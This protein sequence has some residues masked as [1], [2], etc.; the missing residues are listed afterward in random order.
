[1][2]R[3]TLQQLCHFVYRRDSCCY[4]TRFGRF[5]SMSNVKPSEVMLSSTRDVPVSS[6]AWVQ[7]PSLHQTYVKT[8]M[9]RVKAE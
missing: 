7:I 4:M 8:K 5:A 3:V 2:E 9:G 1:M 6:E